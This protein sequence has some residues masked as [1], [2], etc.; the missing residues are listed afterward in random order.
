MY[1]RYG[2]RKSPF[3]RKKQWMKN[4]GR[5]VNTIPGFYHSHHL[6]RS[7]SCLVSNIRGNIAMKRTYTFQDMFVLIYTPYIYNNHN[8]NNNHHHHHFF[9]L[10]VIAAAAV[11]TLQ[12]L[13]PSVCICD[14]LCLRYLYAAFY[15]LFLHIFLSFFSISASAFHESYIR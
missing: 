8:N 2:K 5:W 14:A 9:F 13:S 15:M 3:C 12:C 7:W 11:A 1:W 4:S 6:G 10:T